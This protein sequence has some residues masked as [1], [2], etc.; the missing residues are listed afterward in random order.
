VSQPHQE[1]LDAT[2]RLRR[3]SPDPATYRQDEA[4][5]RDDARFAALATAEQIAELRQTLLIE[6]G[7]LW[8]F[9]YRQDDDI[10]EIKEEIGME[11]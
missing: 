6:V 10:D 8:G 4:D 7:A 3:G 5:R 2:T 9:S 1:V 11:V